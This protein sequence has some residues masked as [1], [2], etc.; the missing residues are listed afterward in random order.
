M[1]PHILQQANFFKVDSPLS[2]YANNVAS[3]FGEDGILKRIFELTPPKYKFCV[4]FG[5]WDGRHLSNCFNLIENH[6]WASLLIEGNPEKFQALLSHHGQNKKVTCLNEFVELEGQQTL[7][8]IMSRNNVPVDFDLLSIDVDGTDYFI[9][10]GLQTYKPKIVVIE[11][12]P[13]IPND[14]IFVQQKDNRINQ[15]SSL[16][17]LILLGKQKGYELICCTSCNAI[18]VQNHIYSQF[19]IQSNLIWHLYKPLQDGRIFHGYDGTVYVEGMN[20]LVW[21]NVT[22]SSENFQVIPISERRFGD[23]QLR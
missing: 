17:A 20:K 13:T 16:L 11:F 19:N 3:Q 2:A 12:N 23:S 15:G 9:W 22:L 5:A 4:E 14:I 1:N 10:E 8:L 21:H 7:D 18:F 6:S